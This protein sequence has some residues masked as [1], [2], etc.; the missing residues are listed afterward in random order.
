MLILLRTI[1]LALMLI[2]VSLVYPPLRLGG[3]FFILLEASGMALIAQLFRRPLQKK[4]PL[5]TLKYLIAFLETLALFLGS[6]FLSGVNLP[7]LG[8]LLLYLGTVLIETVLPGQIEGWKSKE[9]GE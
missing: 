7:F 5:P 4:I 8:I 2:M 6:L 1:L 3:R 9:G